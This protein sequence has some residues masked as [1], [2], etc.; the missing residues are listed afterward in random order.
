ML[1]RGSILAR[2]REIALE[3]IGVEP[4]RLIPAATLRDIGIDSFQFIELV[5]LAEEAFEIKLDVAAMRV[6]TV[7]DVVEVIAGAVAAR[8]GSPQRY[9]SG[10]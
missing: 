6:E 8:N 9:P 3:Q 2:L 7:G 10:P 1:D 4:E 5:F